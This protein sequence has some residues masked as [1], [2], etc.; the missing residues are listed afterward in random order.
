MMGADKL[1]G[2]FQRHDFGILRGAD[3][4]KAF[5]ESY[6]KRDCSIDHDGMKFSRNFYGDIV[7][8][9]R[10]DYEGG[11]LTI[12]P[13]IKDYDPNINY[14][15]LKRFFTERLGIALEDKERMQN[16]MNN[17]LCFFEQNSYI[18]PASTA[19]QR[20]GFNAGVQSDDIHFEGT[21]AVD[22]ADLVMKRDIRADLK[23]F[24]VNGNQFFARETGWRY[25]AEDQFRLPLQSAF[26][27][28][29]EFKLDALVDAHRV[30]YAE[31]GQRTVAIDG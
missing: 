30:E 8:R 27:P 13:G 4:I 28:H 22:G 24:V 14:M 11:V 17:V 16:A 19:C 26:V 12:R 20:L 1:T 31:R 25:Q 2:A 21:I 7:P 5:E 15:T 3:A 10:V 23:E 18:Y 9:C 29:P 6:P